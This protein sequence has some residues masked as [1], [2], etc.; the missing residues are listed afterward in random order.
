VATVLVIL[1]HEDG[2]VESYTL[3]DLCID[4]SIIALVAL[5][6]QMNL[7]QESAM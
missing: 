6:K 3:D 5:R 2:F 7:R 4:H 1:M